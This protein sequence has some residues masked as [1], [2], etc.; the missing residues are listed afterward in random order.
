LPSD[1]QS[2]KIEKHIYTVSEITQAIKGLLEEKIGEVWLE[3]EISNFKAAS[4][5]H[6][7]FR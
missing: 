7:Y 5:G 4:S 6:F 1:R 2:H 3:G